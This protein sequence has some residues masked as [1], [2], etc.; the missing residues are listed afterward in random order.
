MPKTFELQSTLPK[1]P[2]P[3]LDN[4]LNKYFQTLIPFCGSKEE[5]DTV[6]AIVED[7][8]SGLGKELQKRLEDHE[9]KTAFNWLDRWWLRAAYHSWREPLMVNSNWFMV[10]ADHK[11]QPP[12]PLHPKLAVVPPGH[13]TPFQ[14]YRAAGF[15]VNALGM[16]EAIDAETIPVEFINRGK[17]PLCMEQYRLMFGWTRIPLAECDEN[18]CPGG[19]PVNK[20][21]HITVLFRS[22]IYTVFVYD[23]N[24]G[25]RLSVNDIEKLLWHVVFDVVNSKDLEPPV[26]I[27]TSDHRDRW[28]AAREHLVQL[29]A[30]NRE[31]LKQIESSLF[32]LCLD[33]WACPDDY[34]SA[35]RNMAHAGDGFNRWYDKAIS[36]ICM[37]NGKGGMNGEHSP[38]DALIPSRLM[39]WLVENEPA[40]DPEGSVQ[41]AELIEPKKLQFDIDGVIE[42]AID[43][44][45]KNAK[46][47]IKDC[48]ARVLIYKG[49]GSTFIK[50]VAKQS[51]DAYIQMVL[52]LAYYRMHG[53]WTAT[54]ETGSTRQFLLGRT[55]TIRVCSNDAVAF[56]K[57][58]T[59]NKAST[60][61][62][63][64]ALTKACKAH[65][66]YTLDSMKGEGVDRHLLGLRLSLRGGESHK[67]FTHP[68][69]RESTN[70]RL[71]TSS[72]SSGENYNGTGFG[73]VVPDGYGTNYC[74]GADT[75]KF[76]MESKRLC[77]ETSSEKF[78][79]A[80]IEAFADMKTLCQDYQNASEKS[81]L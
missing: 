77:R 28:A 44:A 14:I 12:T 27:L 58:F 38:C 13:V 30:T 53:K 60:K 75:I 19:F 56:V 34:H 18:V 54:Y 64:D 6:K 81:R 42:S 69:M 11:L 51:P 3:P 79:N 59:N 57:T 50:N 71:S 25:A 15:V 41:H 2:V 9:K 20:S 62:K 65:S 49:Y 26:C 7:F 24:T 32:C 61:E 80:I 47:I 52:Q 76:G 72:L 48:D 5:Q 8:R 63:F 10:F 40:K 33:D 43:V 66:K 46:E 78:I 68:V 22:Q 37:S 4:T 36:I 16:K 67:I 55:E 35:Y 45:I 23:K 70:F 29:S 31:S 74:V 17:T 73:A 39:D 1:L 21:K